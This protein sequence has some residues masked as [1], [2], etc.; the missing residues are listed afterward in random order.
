VIFDTCH[1]GSGVNDKALTVEDLNRF[2]E[3]AGRYILSSCEPDQL[4]YEDA[5]NGFF[6]KSLID[7]LRSRQGCIRMT[8]LFRAVQK[9]VGTKVQQRFQKQQRPVMAS[10][11]NSSEIVLGVGVGGSSEGCLAG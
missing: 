4:S 8:D 3:G 9:D 6:T 5:G 1:S 11:E 10:S 2:R 7:Q